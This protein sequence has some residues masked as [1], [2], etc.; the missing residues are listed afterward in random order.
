VDELVRLQAERET[1][2]AALRLAL[3]FVETVYREH[4]RTYL[5]NSG[6]A[7]EQIQAA[8]AS[9]GGET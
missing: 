8:L 5:P 9:V 4:G 1:L 3:S 2:I 7:L 6:D